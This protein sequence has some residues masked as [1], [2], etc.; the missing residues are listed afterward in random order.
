[1]FIISFIGLYVLGILK[2]SSWFYNSLGVIQSD[3]NGLLLFLLISPLFIF[4]IKPLMA[5]YSRKNEF[6]ADAYSLEHT[7]NKEALISMLKRL[8]ANNL[9]HLTPHPLMVFLS[10]SHPPVMDRNAAVNNR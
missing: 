1:M 2:D 5:Y 6:E 9:S 4:F 10:Y 8:A 3:A 7:Q